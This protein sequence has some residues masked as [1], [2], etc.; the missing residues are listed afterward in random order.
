[1]RRA[2]QSD[3]SD[4]EWNCLKSHLPAPKATGR[5]RL[6]SLR[7][8]LD[9]IFYVLKSGCAWRLL[10]H[11]LEHPGRPSTTTSASGAWTGR[12][13]GCTQPYASA[14]GYA[15]RGILSLAPQ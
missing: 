12:G 3:L 13:R 1:M 2:F 6:H 9:S 7:E 10:P 15:S 5:P 11:D 4:A 8:V 14:L